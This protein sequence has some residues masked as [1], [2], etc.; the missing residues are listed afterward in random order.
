MYNNIE[1]KKK[2]IPGMS[3]IMHFRFSQQEIFKLKGF[4]EIFGYWASYRYFIVHEVDEL[5]CFWNIVKCG[6]Q[7]LSLF[8]ETKT[9]ARK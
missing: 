1:K 4:H 5:L 6:Y 7:F 2:N 9:E 8:Q 3:L